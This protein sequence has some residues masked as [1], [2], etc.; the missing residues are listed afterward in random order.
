MRKHPNM[1]VEKFRVR[2]GELGSDSSYG[3][4]GAFIL[5]M[6]KNKINRSLTPDTI[7]TVM[8]L[9]IASDEELW[10]HLSVQ[11][12]VNP[13]RLST[14]EEMCYVKGMFFMD[15]ETVVQFHPKK[16]EYINYHSFVLHMWSDQTQEHKLP[17]SWMVGPKGDRQ[18]IDK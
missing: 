3:N 2:E 10:D 7:N 8:L 15:D 18:E 6:N 12:D 16:S 1:R 5:K 11:I 17:H 13:R 4:N 14:W 9:V